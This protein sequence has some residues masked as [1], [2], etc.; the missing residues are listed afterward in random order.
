MPTR[1]SSHP[2]LINHDTRRAS[3][4]HWINCINGTL[5]RQLPP[6]LRSSDDNNIAFRLPLAIP[7]NFGF[8]FDPFGLNLVFIGPKSHQSMMR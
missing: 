5:L 4:L 6:L 7:Q 3:L 1:F 2:M 8:A